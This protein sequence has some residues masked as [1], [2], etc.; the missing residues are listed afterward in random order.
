MS[1]VDFCGDASAP[2]LG[3]CVIL[4]HGGG[5]HKNFIGEAEKEKFTEHLRK[6]RA[7][8]LKVV[9]QHVHSRSRLSLLVD[10]DVGY[11]LICMI[12]TDAIE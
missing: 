11:T 3:K 7:G 1:V 6:G 10:F 12:T 8:W 5:E 2:L 4:I 9:K